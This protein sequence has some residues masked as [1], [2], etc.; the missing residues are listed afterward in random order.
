MSA[1]G[2]DEGRAAA[3]PGLT[4]PEVGATRAGPL[5][6]GYRHLHVRHRLGP[7]DLGAV[8]RALLT[9]RVHAAARVLVDAD[10]PVADVGVDVRTRLG[11]GPLRLVVPCRVV[12]AETGERAVGFGYGS[13]PGHPFVGEE[14]FRVERDDDGVL[15]FVVDAFSR[16]AWA[17]LVPLARAVPVVQHAYLRLLAHGARRL[18]RAG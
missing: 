1:A 17:W 6:G 10:A 18:A 16:P 2:R 11:V 7:G 15:W 5:P 8:G 9:W 3:R 4:Y 13:L 12:W 14:A